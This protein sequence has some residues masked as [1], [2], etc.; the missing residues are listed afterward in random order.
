MP[1]HEKFRP[2]FQRRRVWA[3]PTVLS[4]DRKALSIKN[5]EPAIF[6]C[7]GEAAPQTVALN[8]QIH[9]CFHWK[10]QA[11][12]LSQGN[13]ADSHFHLSVN[14]FYILIMHYKFKHNH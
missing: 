1:L 5:K 2:P 14:F 8:V 11:K 10:R 3:A 4:L 13:S 12:L 6:T 9:S 7:G